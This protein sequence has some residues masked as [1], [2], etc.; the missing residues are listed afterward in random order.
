M[1]TKADALQNKFLQKLI[2]QQSPVSIFLV[3]GIRL[4]GCITGFDEH[5]ISVRRILKESAE[6]IIFK[7]TISIVRDA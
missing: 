1:T 3:N 7:H 5:T 2:T 4:Q 6:Q